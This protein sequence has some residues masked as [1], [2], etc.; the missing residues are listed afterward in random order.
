MLTSRTQLCSLSWKTNIWKENRKRG[1]GIQPLVP[2]PQA[3]AQ[4]EA[5][6]NLGQR[7]WHCVEEEELYEKV[8]TE[9]L[10][11]DIMEGRPFFSHP[12]PCSP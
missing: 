8:V 3:R 9:W 2:T 1:V 7:D 10:Q 11:K 4:A 5:P 12:G 6:L